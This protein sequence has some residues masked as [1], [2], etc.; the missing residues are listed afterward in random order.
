M[1]PGPQ[2]LT[3]GR[4]KPRFVE[5]PWGSKYLEPL[6]PNQ[7]EK[8]GEVWFE[9]D[10]PL[11]L[12]VKFIFTTDKLSVQVHP[13][14]EYAA[15]HHN[16]PGKTE[17]WHV[18]AAQPGAQVEVGFVE[19]LSKEQLREAATSGTIEPLLQ[20]YDARPGDTF[21]LPA[22]TV[23]AI[24][25]GLVMCEIQQPSDITYRLYDYNRGR[26]LHLD[27]ALAVSDL[28]PFD[29]R[30]EA[31]E[32][33]LVACN[34]FTT[35]LVRVRGAAELP[36]HAGQFVVVIGGKGSIAR[37]ATRPGDAWF[38][39]SGMVPVEGQLDLLVA[40]GRSPTCQ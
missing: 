40:W 24:G 34:H 3:L 19:P 22:G 27:H 10:H 2:P 13:G 4:L 7:S 17:M 23:H 35:S 39:E 28:E 38:A 8:T 6:F 31:R 16:S 33:L 36:E 12:L 30:A 5:K 25:P 20:K 29:P 14:D 26:E 9:A 32:G 18:V 21:F 15:L 1:A 37:N 11:P